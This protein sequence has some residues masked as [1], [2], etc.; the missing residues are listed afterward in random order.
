MQNSPSLDPRGDPKEREN[1]STVGR[2]KVPMH[3][4][5]RNGALHQ[6]SCMD[7]VVSAFSG[8]D[9]TVS[10]SFRVHIPPDDISARIDAPG[11][12]RQRAGEIK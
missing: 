3:A 10:M 8:S 4:R 5:K 2:F 11:G 1:R 12:R 7:G 6:P 9:K